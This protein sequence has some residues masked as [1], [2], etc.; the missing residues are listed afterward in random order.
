[1]KAYKH[2]IALSVLAST[3]L[4]VL[5]FSQDFVE[6]E[7]PT[8]VEHQLFGRSAALSGNFALIGAPQKDVD[9]RQS[10]GSVF[11]YRQ[12][13][14]GWVIS[15][16]VSPETLPPLSNFGMSLDIQNYHAA[17]GSMGSESGLFSEAVYIYEYNDTTWSQKQVLRPSDA[18][19]GSRFGTEVKFDSYPWA[20]Q[21]ILAVGAYQADGKEPKSGAVYIFES[22]VEGEWIQT[23]KLIADDGKSHDYFG[24]TVEFKNHYAPE[25]QVIMV[26][27]YNADGAA[28]RSGAVYFFKRD[29]QGEWQQTDKIFDPN[30]SS[31]DLFG[32]SLK[33]SEPLYIVTK[34]NPQANT[35][36]CYIE[37]QFFIGSP[38]SNSEENGQSGSVYTGCLET[39]GTATLVNELID[40]ASS[41]NEHFGISLGFNQYWGL[42][43][44][45]ANRSAGS[46]GHLYTYET[47]G[48][49][50]EESTYGPG[51]PDLAKGDHYGT[52]IATSE[53]GNVLVASPYKTVGNLENSG[54][55]YFYQY[56]IVPKE[57]EPDIIDD[58][59]LDQNYPNPF[60]PTTTIKYQV[61]EAGNVK[62]SVFNLLGQEVQV[63]VNEQ[64]G[65]GAYSFDFD[66]SSLSSGFYFYRLEVND[67]VEVKKMMLIK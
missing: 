12:T 4:P 67:F 39:D 2:I 35:N 16:E 53:F 57:E 10:V 36:S 66:A 31:S 22:T 29:E 58:Y 9:D 8:A 59:K 63:L 64:Q 32:Y 25:E 43:Y 27:A 54:A 45:G 1:M 5:A 6:S 44:V 47:Y 7:A 48:D 28:E 33:A 41:T 26:G 34:E 38:G 14:D 46:N 11:F 37:D 52:V 42:L 19:P 30:G 13:E 15:E 18:K 49:V 65:N 61:K 55:V 60:N 50:F 62:L 21:N 17:I 51:L 24:Y 3:L 23:A 20:D 56:Q 40:P